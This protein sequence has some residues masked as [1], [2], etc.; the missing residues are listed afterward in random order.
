MTPTE[1]KELPDQL[2][3]ESLTDAIA[4]VVQAGHRDQKTAH[5]V[6]VD[7]VTLLKGQASR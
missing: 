1:L 4:T 2:R 7:V 3:G 6:A 5:E